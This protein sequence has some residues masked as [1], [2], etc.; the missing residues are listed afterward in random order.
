MKLPQQNNKHPTNATKLETWWM[1]RIM[2]KMLATSRKKFDRYILLWD[3]IN[4]RQQFQ[5]LI[6]DNQRN[7]KN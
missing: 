1:Q 2:N 4:D 3:M 6:D 5:V 7:C